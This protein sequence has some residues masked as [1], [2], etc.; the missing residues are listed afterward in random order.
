M[1]LYACVPTLDIQSWKA[2]KILNKNEKE[3]FLLNGKL[4]FFYMLFTQIIDVIVKS[5][6]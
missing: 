3:L 4:K 1:Y 6:L 5:I 2:I